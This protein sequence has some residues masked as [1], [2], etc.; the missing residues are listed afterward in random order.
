MLDNVTRTT[1]AL[2]ATD[3]W[4]HRKRDGTIIEVDI[5]SHFKTFAIVAV[6]LVYRERLI[7]VLWID[8]EKSTGSFTM[9]DCELLGLFQTRPPPLTSRGQRYDVARC[10]ELGI[11]AYLTKPITQAEL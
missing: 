8:K 3:T 6:P 10:Q 1:A 7:G 2:D 11:A 5:T 9:S 4:R